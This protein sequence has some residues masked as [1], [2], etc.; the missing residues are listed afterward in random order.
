M[1]FPPEI[2]TMPDC[3]PLTIKRQRFIQERN[4]LF[5]HEQAERHIVGIKAK[6]NKKLDLSVKT[7]EIFYHNNA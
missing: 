6:A 2:N 1:F 3:S 4:N 7:T 5:I